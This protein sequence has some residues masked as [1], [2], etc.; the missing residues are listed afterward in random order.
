[1]RALEAQWETRGPLPQGPR[2][3]SKVTLGLVAPEGQ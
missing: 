2:G 3:G 1:M